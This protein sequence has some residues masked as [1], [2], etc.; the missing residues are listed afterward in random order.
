MSWR[1]RT[2]GDETAAAID[3]ALK[4]LIASAFETARNVLMNNRQLLDD[5]T[6]ELLAHELSV[7]RISKNWLRA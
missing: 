1:P 4:D 3:R 7:S 2:Y 6:G 5:G